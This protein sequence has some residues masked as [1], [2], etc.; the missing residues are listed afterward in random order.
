MNVQ[1][2]D[3]GLVRVGCGNKGDARPTGFKRQGREVMAHEGANHLRRGRH[4]ALLKSSL[5]SAR[6]LRIPIA[7]RE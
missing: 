4:V 5:V 3:Q 7:P 6:E 1:R 2:G